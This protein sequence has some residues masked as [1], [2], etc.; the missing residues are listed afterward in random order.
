MMVRAGR[1][2][3]ACAKRL[4][5]ALAGEI[6]VQGKATRRRHVARDRGLR[7]TFACEK[8]RAIYSRSIRPLKRQAD[9]F[10]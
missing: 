3:F 2:I 8:A 9:Q 7:L 5:R 4:D 6:N 1:L 10:P